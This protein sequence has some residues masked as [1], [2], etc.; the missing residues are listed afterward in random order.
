MRTARL[1]V[2]LLAILAVTGCQAPM[3]EP[4]LDGS[5]AIEGET[6]SV[7]PEPVYAGVRTVAE[8][9]VPAPERI[10][11]LPNASAFRSLPGF[12]GGNLPRFYEVLG[13]VNETVPNGSALERMENGATY[14]TGLIYILPAAD[15][16]PAS[17]EW[18][19][20]HEFGHYVN[21]QLGRVSDLGAKL[22]TST[23]ESY[24]AGALREGAT[25]F[26][27][28]TYLQR[29][30]NRTEPTAPMYERLLSTLPAGEYTRFSLSKY[31]HG[32][33]YVSNR[34]NDPSE[35][36]TV[37]SQPPTTSEQLLHGYLPDEEPPAALNV[38]VNESDSWRVSRTDRLG[39]AF[40]RYALENGVATDR[41]VEAAAGW[42]VDR[43]YYLQPD[44][45]GHTSYAW[46]FRW[47][48]AANASEFEQTLEAYLDE[49]G[50]RRGDVW[51]MMAQSSAAIRS[52]SD[53][54]TVVLLG[55]RTLV[56]ETTVTAAAE[57][58][59]RLD[60]PDGSNAENQS[61]ERSD[62]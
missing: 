59:V 17:T 21:L 8:A 16:D 57:G 38:T 3:E 31:V 6:I 54:T 15:A 28:D 41:A 19:L 53:R 4:Q 32:Y 36:D 51:T 22:G 42:G 12:S 60:L 35:L 61:S 37:F 11:V 43:L 9:D 50:D 25:V 2:A 24:V 47:D 13:F 56:S 7:S 45:E 29:Y 34:V 1:A 62:Q 44:G 58:H 10:S 30:G 55:N 18:V 52:P 48:D 40:L 46:T 14:N 26:T 33:R 27:T 49:R 23:D 39:E 20:A 5:I